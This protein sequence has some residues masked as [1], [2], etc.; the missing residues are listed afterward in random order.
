MAWKVHFF[1]TSRGDLPV[2]DFIKKQDKYL[3]TR[4]NLS[5]RLLINNGPYLKPPY[6][7]KLQGKLYELRISGKI[8]VRIFYT[9]RNGEYFLLHAFKKKSQKTPLKELKTALDRMKEL[10]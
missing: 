9:I 4:T 1:K 6:S 10:V 2:K 3:L 5:I 8:A 7:K